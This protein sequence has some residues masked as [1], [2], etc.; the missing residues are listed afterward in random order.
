MRSVGVQV[1]HANRR[2][3]RQ[4]DM[5]KLIL[6]L[7]NFV[8]VPQKYTKGKQSYKQYTKRFIN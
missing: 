1:F 4:T 2:T 8:N 5:T 7:R 3:D 6:T